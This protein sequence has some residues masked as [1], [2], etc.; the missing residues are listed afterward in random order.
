M[1]II[2]FKRKIEL[3]NLFSR[4]NI[5]INEN[6]CEK[7]FIKKSVFLPEGQYKIKIRSGL[8]ES[9]ELKIDILEKEER[10]LNIRGSVAGRHGRFISV[11]CV[12]SFLLYLFFSVILIRSFAI[13]FLLPFFIYFF[14][15]VYSSLFEK[16]KNRINIK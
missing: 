15:P 12:F 3:W 16:N 8:F 5:Y 9:N 13:Y 6:K 4:Y 1:G 7:I 2:N 10:T 11:V 14:M